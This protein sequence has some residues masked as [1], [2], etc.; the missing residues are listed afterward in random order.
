MSG[1]IFILVVG[2]L[3]GS[4]SW[5]IYRTKH[6][7]LTVTSSIVGAFLGLVTSSIVLAFLVE[8]GPWGMV[9]EPE[10]LVRILTLFFVGS[11]IGAMLA[12][13]IYMAIE[14]R[15]QAKGWANAA[16]VDAAKA[17]EGAKGKAALTYSVKAA[18]ASLFG[19]RA[20]VKDQQRPGATKRRIFISYRRQI[21]AALAGRIS[22]L[23][24]HED[25]FDI[26]MD[27]DAILL[28][29]DFVKA[30]NEEVAKSNVLIAV[31][32]RDWLDTRDEAG[33]RRLDDPND[34][35]RLGIAAALQRQIPV[36]PILVDGAK[37]PKPEQLPENLQQLVRRNA[38]DLRN[39]S[40][41]ADMG[42]L[43]QELKAE[44]RR[45]P[46]TS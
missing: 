42:R 46:G 31:I 23:L 25:E 40:F 8:G 34:F 20:A 11:S 45:T 12:V 44:P 36:V 32:G 5:R 14:R 2:V 21:D 41:K 19:G 43:V 27:V 38:L 10:L 39:A 7:G 6:F 33:D 17:I 4:V 22:D 24:A 15:W 35:V 28:G 18:G 3:I 16:E 37:I 29:A 30:I 9:S 26:F 13:K 1:L